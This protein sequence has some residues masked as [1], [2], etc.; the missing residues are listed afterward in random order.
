MW[1]RRLKL[2][3][4]IVAAILA[5]AA[6]MV[7]WLWQQR[8]PRMIDNWPAPPEPGENR[9]TVLVTWL[10]VTTLLFDDG[11]TQILIDGFFSRPTIAEILLRRPVDNDAAMIDLALN[12]FQVRHLAAIIPSHSHWDH[13]MDVGAVAN[14][15][16][17]SV[18]GSESTAN[19]ARGAGVP[20]DQIVVAETGEPYVF[21]DFR[22]TLLPSA[23]API[24]WRGGTP[25]SGT[26]DEPLVMPQPVTAMREGGSFA[27]VIEHPQGTAIVQGSAGYVAEP[28]DGVAAD[29]VLVSVFGFAEVDDEYARGFWETLVTRTGATSV[30]ALHFDDFTRPLGE[31][32]PWPYLIMDLEETGRLLESFR[33]QWDK[34]TRLYLPEYGRPIAIYGHASSST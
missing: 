1:L 9:G 29:V 18:L 17:A 21:G 31:I 10:G 15:T 20:E 27:I 5:V 23:H 33:D 13:A 32:L 25:L 8:P 28:L 11:E 22:V 30:Y 7:V 6:A 16:N 12:E 2:T 24:G 26:V 34:D 14:R 3:A 4:S 19:I